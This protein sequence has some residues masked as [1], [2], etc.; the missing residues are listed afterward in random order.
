MFRE[1]LVP[2]QMKRTDRKQSCLMLQVARRYSEGSFYALL[3]VNGSHRCILL[4]WGWDR[5]I[6]QVENVALK[7]R[8][9]LSRAADMVLVGTGKV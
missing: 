2:A 4:I 1:W 5:G 3:Q 7:I 6:G 9:S 8:R